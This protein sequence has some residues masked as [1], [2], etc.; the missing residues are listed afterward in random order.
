MVQR[1]DEIP[2]GDF[3]ENDQKRI[4]EKQVEA[5]KK[6][7]AIFNCEKLMDL[8]SREIVGAQDSHNHAHQNECMETMAMLK[9]NHAK[10][11]ACRFSK[12][13]TIFCQDCQSFGDQT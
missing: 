13:P 10:A 2:A 12:D 11:E 3:W 9:E 7:K 6:C 4:K 8:V 1:Y 5:A